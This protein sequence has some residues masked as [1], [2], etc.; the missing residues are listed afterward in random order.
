M[1]NDSWFHN[2]DSFEIEKGLMADMFE[3][4]FDAVTGAE[5]APEALHRLEAAGHLLRLDRNIEPARFRGTFVSRPEL[6][7]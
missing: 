7:R 5:S 3:S 4:F 2:R 6:V 1:P